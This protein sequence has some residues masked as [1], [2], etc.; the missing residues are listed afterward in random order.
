ME[1]VHDWNEKIM[2]LIEKLKKDHPEL[3]GFLDEMNNTLPSSNDPQINISILRDYF[4]TLMNLENLQ[5]K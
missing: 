5:Q 1:T 2:T 4:D 3:I